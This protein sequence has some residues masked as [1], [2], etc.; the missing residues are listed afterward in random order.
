MMHET[1]LLYIH[2]YTLVILF[3][4]DVFFLFILCKN[5][6]FLWFMTMHLLT[7]NLQT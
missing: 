6:T 4:P 3:F 2:P 7:L 5:P 1:Q